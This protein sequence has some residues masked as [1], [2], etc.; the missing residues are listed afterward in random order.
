MDEPVAK[1]TVALEQRYGVKVSSLNNWDDVFV[2][3]YQFAAEGMT[4][5]HKQGSDGTYPALRF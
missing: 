4:E 3:F 1:P 2:R 5:A